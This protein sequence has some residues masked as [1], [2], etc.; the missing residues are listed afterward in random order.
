MISEQVAVVT[1]NTDE[2]TSSDIAIVSEIISEI[3]DQDVGDAEVSHAQ[4]LL[5][6]W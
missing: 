4:L 5:I 3:A 2:I 6:T 1:S